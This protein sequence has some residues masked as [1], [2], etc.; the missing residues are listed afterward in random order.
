MLN[1]HDAS[2]NFGLR[3]SDGEFRGRLGIRGDVAKPW[4]RRRP[5]AVFL[6]LL[7]ERTGMD[8]TRVSASLGPRRWWGGLLVA[9]VASMAAGCAV[10]PVSGRSEMAVLSADEERELGDEEAKK[11]EASMGLVAD[12]A[13]RCVRAGGRGPG[14][15]A[16]TPAGCPLHLPDRQ[17]AGAERLRA[18]QREHLHLAG[19]AGPGELRG[20]AGRRPGARGRP[21]GGAPH[22]A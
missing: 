17:S 11:V 10:N 1:R 12:P 2:F 5:Q 8:A 14:R 3:I 20:R 22:R 15:Q 18:S 16:V 4:G 7:K 13:L 21:R 19:A 9:C 6:F